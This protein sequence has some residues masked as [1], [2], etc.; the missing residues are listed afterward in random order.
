MKHEEISMNTKKTLAAAL[1]EAMKV[2]PFQKI[3]VSELIKTCHMNRKTFYYHF[4]DIYA[5][6]KWTFEQEAIEVVKHF[7]LLVD[8][9]EAIHFVMDYVEENDYVINCAYDSIGR[10]ELKRFFYADFHE[11]VASVIEQAENL[12]GQ[13]LE[14]GYKDFLCSFYAEA[15]AGILIDWI[16]NRESRNRDTVIRYISDTIRKSLIGILS[17]K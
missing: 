10:D 3:T 1:K 2:K 13:K 17:S 11:I 5:L 6:L 12:A 15:I 9:E 7:N 16:K 8:Y 4:E 14:D